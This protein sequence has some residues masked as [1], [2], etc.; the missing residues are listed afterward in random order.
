MASSNLSGQPLG[1]YELREMIG[2]GGMGAVYLGYQRALDRL[3]AVKVMQFSLTH[4]GNFAQRFEREAKTAAALEHPHIVPVIDYGFDQGTS[5]IVMR[6]LS[7]GT[8]S[9]RLRQRVEGGDSPPSLEEIARLLGQVA[10]ALDYAHHQKVI[11]RDIKTRNIMFDNHGEAYLVDFGIAKLT[12]SSAELT[13][14]GVALGT[15]HY[16]APEQVKGQALTPATDQYALAVVIY[17]LVAG[18]MPFEAATPFAVQ[19]RHISD[20]PTPVHTFRTQTPEAV[21]LV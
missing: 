1:Q 21:T 16:M 4:G 15:A 10:S 12:E 6:Y 2:I 19:Q 17:A 8:L 11:H 13:M 3:V 14:T 9:Q 7:G 20:M 5:F 18:R